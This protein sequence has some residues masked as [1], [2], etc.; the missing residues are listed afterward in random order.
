[1]HCAGTGAK[2]RAQ[3]QQSLH[4]SLVPNFLAASLNMGCEEGTKKLPGPKTRQVKQGGFT[5]GRR[6]I[7]R[8]SYLSVAPRYSDWGIQ[9]PKLIWSAAVAIWQQCC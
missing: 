2:Q 6:R 9:A 4:G 1:M 7:R 5:S 8:P 3:Y